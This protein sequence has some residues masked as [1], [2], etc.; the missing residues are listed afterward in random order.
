MRLI[1]FSS[2]MLRRLIVG[3]SPPVPL[4]C[5]LIFMYWER[6]VDFQLFRISCHSSGA[7]T[8]PRSSEFN[9]FASRSHT[10]FFSCSAKLLS[11]FIA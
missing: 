5:C 3:P 9:I 4:P 1:N 11:S 8:K 10:L 6:T 2:S 7:F